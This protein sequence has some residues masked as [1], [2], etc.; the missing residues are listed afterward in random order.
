MNNTPRY[1]YTTSGPR[2]PN[3]PSTSNNS[4]GGAQYVDIVNNNNKYDFQASKT[5]SQTRQFM[6]FFKNLNK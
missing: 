2:R 6:N 3:N 4:A 1:G 5:K